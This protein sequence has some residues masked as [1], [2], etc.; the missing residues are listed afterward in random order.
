MIILR[1]LAFIGGVLIIVRVMLSVMQLLVIPRSARDGM[2]AILFI[3][4]RRVFNLLIDRALTYEVRD[5]I[6]APYGPLA[7]LLLVPY[8]LTFLTIGGTGMFWAL[9]VDNLFEAFKLSGSSLLTL[10]FSPVEGWAQ[11]IVAFFLATLGL[12]IIALLI[13]YLPVIYDTFQQRETQVNVLEVRAGR[14]PS[15]VEMLS[16][17]HRI[18]RFESL[19]ELW[20]TWELWFAQTEE[21]H[22]S[23]AVLSFFRSPSPH[24]SWLTAAGTILDA[25]SLTNAVVDIPRDARADTC[26]RAGF[27]ALRAIADFFQ[28]PHDPDPLPT[29][30]ISIT[31]REFDIAC[32]ELEGSG[33]PLKADRDQAWRDFAG[34]RVNYDRVLLSLAQLVVAPYARWSS[35]RSYVAQRKSPRT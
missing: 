34:W 12:M 4:L 35:D 3:I 31:R 28:I 1:V 25:A 6:M 15:A 10:G 29:D 14:P 7:L 2:A 9:G 19:Y 26:I 27:L 20:E 13:A 33:V 21:S 32:D 8:W 30:P 22:T 11:T 17:L 23:L 18:G 16:R 5:A 24:R